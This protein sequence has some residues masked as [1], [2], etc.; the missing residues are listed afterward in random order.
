MQGVRGAMNAV[1]QAIREASSP[2]ERNNGA[3]PAVGMNAR[4]G[5]PWLKQPKFNWKAQDKHNEMQNF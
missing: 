4:A 5:R 2:P 1:V 3:A